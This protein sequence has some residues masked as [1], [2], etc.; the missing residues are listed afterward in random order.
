M[1]TTDNKNTKINISEINDT[2]KRLDAKSSIE[3]KIK[4]LLDVW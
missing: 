4:F 1:D 3:R 2:I